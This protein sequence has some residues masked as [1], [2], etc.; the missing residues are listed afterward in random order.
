MVIMTRNQ[1]S[2]APESREQL[3]QASSDYAMPMGA[4]SAHRR[5]LWGTTHKV[6]LLLPR[7]MT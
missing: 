2:Q 6:A 3:P 1:A 5:F 4:K 7:I